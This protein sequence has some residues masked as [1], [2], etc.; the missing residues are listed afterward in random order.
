MLLLIK[1]VI[2]VKIR[3]WD[4]L[5]ALILE[6]GQQSTNAIEKKSV[7]IFFILNISSFG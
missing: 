5:T 4:Y 7:F 6:M 2:S 3:I 1:I